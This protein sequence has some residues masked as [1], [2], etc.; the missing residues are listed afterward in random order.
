MLPTDTAFL[1]KY[2]KKPCMQVT[3]YTTTPN[4]ADRSLYHAQHILKISWKSVHALSRNVAN[5]QTDKE[6]NLQTNRDEKITFAV[7]RR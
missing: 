4:F 6:T 7:R 3:E 2:K 5:R 1:G